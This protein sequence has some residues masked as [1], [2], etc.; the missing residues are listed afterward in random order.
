M[1]LTTLR[2][3]ECRVPLP[4]EIRLGNTRITTRDFVCLRLETDGGIHGEA[5]GYVRGTPLFVVLESLARRIVGA[6]DLEMRNALMVALQ[7]SNQPGRAA[8]SRAYS[9]LDIALWDIMARTAGLPLFQILGGLRRSVGATAVAG[10]YLDR[11]TID[12]VADEVAR[13]RDEGYERVKI[14]LRGYDPAFDR[15]L[16][17]RVTRQAPGRLAVDSHWSWRDINAARRD[18]LG[19]DDFGLEFIEDPFSTVDVDLIGALRR[20]IRTPIAAGEDI[21][22]TRVMR[23]LAAE[24][25][26]LRVDATTC[27]GITAAVEA[28]HHADGAGKTVFPHVFLPL[29]VH[30]AAAFPGIEGVE[31]IPEELGADPLEKLL[32]RPMPIRDGVARV[33]EEPGVGIALDWEAVDRYA[34]QSATVTAET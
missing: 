22:G 12:D 14:M 27:G 33:D 7:D 18:C 9:L 10:Y 17:E 2:V 13:L 26:I 29:H 25:D 5:L 8:L 4:Q 28:I 6:S 21:H 3:A 24:V 23:N 16:I 32:R 1:K 11:R 34:T 31:M 19:L 15:A 20:A 30:L